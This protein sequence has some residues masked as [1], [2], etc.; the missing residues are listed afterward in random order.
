M[1]VLFGLFFYMGFSALKGLQV[2][3]KLLMEKIENNSLSFFKSPNDLLVILM[4][5]WNQD[6]TSQ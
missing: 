2:S 6:V 4:K 1:P 5:T 3:L